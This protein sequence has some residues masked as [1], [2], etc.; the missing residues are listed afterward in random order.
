MSEEYT[1]RCILTLAPFHEF[2]DRFQE[3]LIH[4]GQEKVAAISQ[5][6]FWNAFSRMKM[7]EFHLRFHWNLF[8]RFKWTIFQHWFR[9]IM[10]WR[11]PGVK[12]LSE[13]IMDSLL[14]HICVTRPQWVKIKMHGVDMDVTDIKPTCIQVMAWCVSGTKPLP[15][16]VWPRHLAAYYSITG[17]TIKN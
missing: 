8:L 4:W 15:E 3:R 14:M 10:A 2:H 6:T 13:W 9:L 5:T 7:Y 17:E 12:P 16:P 1:F 11:Q